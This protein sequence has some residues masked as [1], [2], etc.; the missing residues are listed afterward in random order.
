MLGK[1]LACSQS[2]DDW[3]EISG[4]ETGPTDKC[5]VDVWDREDFSRVA[6]FDGSAVQDAEIGAVAEPFGQAGADV[7]V[8]LRDLV[9]GGDFTG[10][11]GPDGFVGDD[12]VFGG[13]RIGD[14][15]CEL[16]VDDGQGFVGFS[17]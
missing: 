2:C 13:C 16:R 9:V 15:A 5:A 12:G 8:D 10:A 3:D 1:S 7:R 4:F 6:G 14:R 17:L 11:D